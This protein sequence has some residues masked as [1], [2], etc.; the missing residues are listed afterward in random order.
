MLYYNLSF[1]FLFF[2]IIWNLLFQ[3]LKYEIVFHV[4]FKE[5]YTCFIYICLYIHELLLCFFLYYS[6]FLPDR[7]MY[8]HKLGHFNKCFFSYSLG[9]CRV[10]QENKCLAK[11]TKR[12]QIRANVTM[13]KNL[14]FRRVFPRKLH[15][16][17]YFCSQICHYFF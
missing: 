8:K 16:W 6:L 10:E 5:C 3:D 4:N 15:Q 7:R 14:N 11:E 13:L 2:Q 1:L 17:I 9:L 12:I